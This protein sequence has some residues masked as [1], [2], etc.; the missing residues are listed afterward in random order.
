MGPRGWR[1]WS[2]RAGDWPWARYQLAQSED[3]SVEEAAL[4]KTAVEPRGK[5]LS[6]ALPMR[7]CARARLLRARV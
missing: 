4:W 3:E 1:R 2:G 7:G 5:I 6:G